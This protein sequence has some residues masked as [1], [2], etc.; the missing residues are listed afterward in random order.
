MASLPSDFIDLSFELSIQKF[1][2]KYSMN[3]LSKPAKR[4]IGSLSASSDL[5]QDESAKL[6]VLQSLFSI[7]FQ[8][9]NYLFRFCVQS[10]AKK[11]QAEVKKTETMFVM[12]VAGQQSTN[13]YLFK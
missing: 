10:Y 3:V 12:F 2:T 8:T 7:D 4:F 11:V 5:T 13:K 6:R 9:T 1:L